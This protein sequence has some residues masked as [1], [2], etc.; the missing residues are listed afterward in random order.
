MEEVLIKEPLLC[1]LGLFDADW[2]RL[3]DTSVGLKTSTRFTTIREEID[4]QRTNQDLESLGPRILM[5]SDHKKKQTMVEEFVNG[6]ISQW[7]G[8]S[9]SELDLN[10]SLYSYGLDSFFSLTFKMQLEATLQVS[11]EV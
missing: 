2:S 4:S 8:V 7:V 9:A 11:F 1:Q 3:M 5:E 6:L 10:T